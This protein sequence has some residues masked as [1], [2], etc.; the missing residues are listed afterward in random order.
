MI[1]QLRSIPINPSNYRC[2]K[3]NPINRKIILN[4]ILIA[5]II[6]QTSVSAQEKSKSIL[7]PSI[8]DFSG[9]FSFLSSGWMEG[10]EVGT[11]G[12]LMAADYIASMMELYKL[13]PNGDRM[14]IN[15]SPSPK[16]CFFQDFEII[17]YKT[18]HSGLAV[19]EQNG[20]TQTTLRL[21]E[22]MDYKIT[23]GPN[24]I[25]AEAPMVFAGYGISAAEKGYD[26]Y[27][28][29]DVKCKILLI[30]DGFPGCKDTSSLAWKKIGRTLADNEALFET[31][32][33]TARKLGAIA[34]VVLDAAEFSKSSIYS[35]DSL[36]LLSSTM[37]LFMPNEPEYKDWDYILPQDLN[38]ASI[39]YFR[40]GK[41]ACNLLL[42][43]TGLDLTAFEKK[44][45]KLLASSFSLLKAK[46][47]RFYATIKKEP[48]LARNIIGIIKG[49]DSTKNIILGAHYDHL[50]TRDGLV[51]NGADDNASGT[52][53]MLAL[54]KVWVQSGKTPPC[55]LIFASWA[56]EEKG[57]L[58]S[59]YF[60]QNQDKLAQ[61]TLLY[62][63]M[64][65]I[66][67]STLED[68]AKIQ[69]SIGTRNGDKQLREIAKQSNGTLKRPFEL[70]LW[71]VT[72]HSGSDYASFTEK[73][74]PIFTFN[75]G[76]HDEYHTPK[77]IFRNADL[78]KMAEVLKVVNNC[79]QMF[80]DS[81]I[82]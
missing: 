55:N 9:T 22:D 65:M 44:T 69:L 66:S 31:K 41:F 53:G 4:F 76:L 68:T 21:T 17:R 45:D 27:K 64:D 36:K 60:A 48:M 70:D 74:I 10:R 79:L 20:D 24:N 59:R 49:A 7:P 28:N 34:L 61:N 57:L 81:I 29:L 37:N 62:I 14:E 51:Y 38:D 2:K 3:L 18:D 6:C 15:V 56:A 46:K 1:I 82:K 80:I 63:N 12:G 11:K 16:L 23:P 77:D 72:G 52:S 58:G 35:L 75:S 54:A 42:M 47:L 71:D 40:L 25:E 32:L 8:S 73:N 67:R 78:E 30:M 50:G 26:D 5:L 39:P 33:Q 43:G 19:I 13:A